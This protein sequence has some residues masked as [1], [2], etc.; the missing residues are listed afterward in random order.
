MRLGPTGCPKRVQGQVKELTRTAQPERVRDRCLTLGLA[1]PEKPSL[2]APG[3]SPGPPLRLVRP[4]PAGDLAGG[5]IR[6]LNVA[7]KCV[8]RDQLIAAFAPF[9]GDG[10][11]FVPARMTIEVG[12]QVKVKLAIKSG[13]TVFEGGGE[14]R[15]VHKGT[16]GAFG[17]EGVLVRIAHLD[18]ANR[19]VWDEMRALKRNQPPGYKAPS[20]PRQTMALGAMDQTASQAAHKK[21]VD[22][23]SKTAAARPAPKAP[24]PQSPLTPVTP[25][26]VVPAAAA[27]A[28]VTPAPVVP[29]SLTTPAPVAI[30]A[31]SPPKVP[32]LRSFPVGSAKAGPAALTPS[33][34]AAGAPIPA[35]PSP[36]GPGPAA[37]AKPAEVTPPPW[38]APPLRKP[39]DRPQD[40]PQDKTP[41]PIAP[42]TPITPIS[43]ASPAPQAKSHHHASSD[44]DTEPT[45]ASA[46]PAAADL[47]FED[48]T[49]RRTAEE[50]G[51]T[52]DAPAPVASTLAS[53]ARVTGALEQRTPGSPFQLP[54]N[55]FSELTTNAL[56]FFVEAT[57][58]EEDVGVPNPADP[59]DFAEEELDSLTEDDSSGLDSAAPD[60][61]AAP[62]P[63]PPPPPLPVLFVAPGRPPVAPAP[64]ALAGSAARPAPAAAVAAPAPLAEVPGGVPSPLARLI[65]EQLSPS[66]PQPASEEPSPSWEGE[67]A[68]TNLRRGEADV[69]RTGKSV[70]SVANGR[71]AALTAMVPPRLRRP[72]L[73]VSTATLGL[74]AGYLLWGG[75]PP[76][77][78]PAPAATQAVAGPI[79]GAPAT[80]PATAIGATAAAPAPPAP[81]T[82]ATPAAPPAS[83]PAAAAPAAPA[84]AAP[85]A[86]SPTPN[87]E[88]PASTQPA[89]APAPAA[90][91]AAAKPALVVPAPAAAATNPPIAPVGG[92][93]GRCYA[94]VD[95]TPVGA[96]VRLGRKKLGKTP[97]AQV[98]IPCGSV[99]LTIER[100]R[101][102]P[103]TETLAATSGQV[104]AIAP[105][106][107]RPRAK[108]TVTS[109]P[110]GATIR[111]NGIA[112]GKTPKVLTVARFETARLTVGDGK[113]RQTVYVRKP[114]VKVH[115]ALGG[116]PA[117]APSA[118]AATKTPALAA[119]PVASTA[120]K[121]VS[122][123]SPAAKPAGKAYR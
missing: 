87:P 26:P 55:P 19:S 112:A 50:V 10:T 122:A 91:P 105:R 28:Q 57:L 56:N 99:A 118:S 30:P 74:L 110:D 97:L 47:A 14:L 72:I 103:V 101:Y 38:M 116:A 68:E 5:P 7:T 2:P 65:H 108:L 54:A 8:T 123:A 37:S 18:A 4:A 61:A 21:V 94:R 48:K 9:C 52:D 35:S 95:S 109:A 1:L 82:G 42:I 69:D 13:D 44:T 76:R 78:G 113:W 53:A 111:L 85:V 31:P 45:V 90:K 81:A 15:E 58:T 64:T 16:D 59:S 93:P 70:P 92:A 11:L 32:P 117:K 25:A 121:P 22:Q 43:K 17:R 104:A 62:L 23:G 41:R 79:A 66:A 12:A 29:A 75:T 114:E 60:D 33:G 3:P 20:P 80:P 115:A 67:G 39:Q 63:E 88:R 107:E 24:V 49:V 86:V 51:L 120:N 71:I 100:S 98:G 77:Q 102:A 40:R 27:P 84:P 83:A 106:L 73:T 89:A 34:L 36:P 6:I 96:T 46:P 119:K